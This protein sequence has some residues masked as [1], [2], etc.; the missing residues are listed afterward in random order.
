MSLVHILMSL[1]CLLLGRA[2]T[3]IFEVLMH[4]CAEWE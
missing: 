2:L 4:A 1:I 3:W